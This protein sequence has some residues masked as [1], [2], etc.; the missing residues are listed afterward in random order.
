MKMKILVLDIETAGLNPTEP[1]VEIGAV[2]VDTDILSVEPVF[3]ELINETNKKI[4]PH[5]WIFEHST[6]KYDEIQKEGKDL[7]DLRQ[8]LQLLFDSYPATAFNRAFDFS[9]LRARGF[10][11]ENVAPDP[12][13]IAKDILNIHHSYYGKKWPKVQECLDYFKINEKEPHRALGDVIQEGRI[14]VELIKLK[15]YPL[16]LIA[17]EINSPH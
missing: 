2:L 14:I 13:F 11:I 17:G 16:E 4:D 7:E 1:I 3:H 8:S 9:F 10:K 5:A 6:L 15:K 12:M